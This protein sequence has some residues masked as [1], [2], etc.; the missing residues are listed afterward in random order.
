MAER[1]AQVADGLAGR[2]QRRITAMALRDP[3]AAALPPFTRDRLL[4]GIHVFRAHDQTELLAIVAGLSAFVAQRPAV[5]LVVL[6]SVAFHF[7]QDL[8][9]AAQ[10]GP[11]WPL[12]HIVL[13]PPVISTCL[14]TRN[15]S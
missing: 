5:R 7:R 12:P 9:D 1:A 3:S 6:D 14:L 11:W 13:S 4:A 15:P 8:Q 2:V 10:V